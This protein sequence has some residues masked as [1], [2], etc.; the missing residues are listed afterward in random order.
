[1]RESGQVEVALRTAETGFLA[2]HFRA[3]CTFSIH[4]IDKANLVANVDEFPRLH[5]DPHREMYGGML[6][7]SGRFQ[8]LQGYR[9]VG[10][11]RCLAEVGSDERAV[12]FDR[13]LPSDLIL[14]DPG[15]RDVT[16]HAIQA[17][18]PQVTLLPIG[19]DRL[20]PGPTSNGQVRYVQ[21][22]ERLNES[23]A[24]T[25]VYDVCVA[26]ADGRIHEQW[27][28]LRLKV[29]RGTEFSGRWAAPVLGSYLQRRLKELMPAAQVAV[30]I[31]HSPDG[32]RQTR[33][34][35]TIQRALGERT[36]IRRRADGRPEVAGDWVISAAHAHGL[37]LAVA[38][39]ADAGA[40][41]CDVEPVTS[42]DGATWQDMLG[43]ERFALATLIARETNDDL[44]TAATRVW[45]AT[46]CLKKAGA[47]L[48]A[49]LML[50]AAH[51]DGWVQLA[52]GSHT[53]AILATAV[54]D[55][56]EELV[57]ALLTNGE[58][59]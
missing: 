46:E 34:N 17:C 11:H 38:G 57:F 45:T 44:D 22:C 36:T 10:A 51:E 53:I 29:M 43:T 30:A 23:D 4:N 27:Q 33:S 50:D 48:N 35:L 2:D 15:V 39:P 6:F 49:T 37:T 24:E 21:A 25:L 12:W 59:E 20:L 52:S 19:V 56:D 16:M 8:R 5:L 13:T 47:A 18:M 1:M 42:R 31:T 26:D 54:W 32:E 14:G 40:L 3:T 9:E 58:R 41:G 7:Q 55:I 28:G